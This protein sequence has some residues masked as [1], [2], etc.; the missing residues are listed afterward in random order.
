MN[1]KGQGDDHQEY[2]RHY[3]ALLTRW[4]F[5]TALSRLQIK[6]IIHRKP[7][8]AAFSASQQAMGQTA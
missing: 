4:P 3:Q 2:Q 8:H 5:S 7:S 6:I 1:Q